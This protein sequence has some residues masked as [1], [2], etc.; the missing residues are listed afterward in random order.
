MALSPP[1]FQSPKTD[2]SSDP[3]LLQPSMWNRMISLLKSL[4]DG[5]DAHGSVLVRDTTDAT[6]GGA[7][8]PS[9][10]GV[11][12]CV[13]PGSLPS[14]QPI[15][16]GAPTAH[17]AT[18]ETGGTDALTMLD[19]SVI[20]TGS[21]SLPIASSG[22]R[23]LQAV[24]SDHGGI[25]NVNCCVGY[26]ANPGDATRADHVLTM[27][28]NTTPLGGRDLVTEPAFEWRIEDYYAPDA[29]TR[30]MEAHWQYYDTAGNGFRPIALT[31]Q[32]A[33]G[34]YQTAAPLT[35]SGSSINF[36]ST[37]GV[38]WASLQSGLLQLH[39]ASPALLIGDTVASDGAVRLP[40]N[41][42]IKWRN[43]GN[44]ADSSVISS[45]SGYCYLTAES[46]LLLGNS[47]YTIQFTNNLFYPTTDNIVDLGYPGGPTFRNLYLGTSLQVGANPAQSGPIRLAYDQPITWRNS[48]NTGDTAAIK[49]GS[50]GIANVIVIGAAL[51]PSID[52]GVDMGGATRRWRN[53]FVSSSIVNKVKAGTP[54]D[55]DVSSAADGMMV[56]DSTANKIWVRLGG[57]WKGVVVA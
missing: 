29:S 22:N 3:T 51:H 33:P 32:R 47:A 19:A 4:F 56:F 2:P 54:T 23:F 8:V 39:G 7:W 27:G 35:F 36:A 20:K 25:S 13:G 48:T 6:D 24:V 21:L 17:H 16:A 5:S 37:T 40:N 52:N 30:M 10:A 14:F 50:N 28:F 26:A 45:Q 15:A 43:A 11:L 9:A 12:T 38:S 46:A 34:A 1:L 55:A 31:I 41:A 18:H 49:F 53:V 44:T 42:T 57:V